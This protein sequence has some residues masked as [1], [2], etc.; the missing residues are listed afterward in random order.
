MPYLEQAIF[1]WVVDGDGCG[2]SL[3]SWDV[4]QAPVGGHFWRVPNAKK[5]SGDAG[6]EGYL[7]AG[8]GQGEAGAEGLH[9]GFFAGPALEE[10]G[11]SFGRRESLEGGGFGG[12]KES[13]RDRA[14]GAVRI[15]K[16]D[17]RS[18]SGIGGDGQK[19]V[20]VGMR[21]VE[22]EGGVVEVWG[23]RRLSAGCVGKGDFPRREI[24]VSGEDVA[25]GG[26]GGD[27]A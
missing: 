19:S 25:Q 11:G 17:I 3:G 13:L 9:I 22:V 26:T 7:E 12:G 24:E 27:E 1:G 21:E 10:G 15:Y 5:R 20:V 6:A 2:V 16:L 18:H 4:M 8:K 23:E 14:G